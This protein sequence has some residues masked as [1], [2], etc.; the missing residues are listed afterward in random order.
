MV[1]RYHRDNKRLQR[2]PHER[3]DR[4]PNQTRKCWVKTERN[5]IQ[6]FRNRNQMDRSSN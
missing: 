6:I 1:G 4:R 3:T 5:Q 2:R